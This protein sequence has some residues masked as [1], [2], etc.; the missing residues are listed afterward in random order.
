ME[1]MI[2]QKKIYE[3]R[4]RK[5]ILD[6]DLAGL[7]EVETRVMNQNVKRNSDRFPEDFMFQLTAVEWEHISSSQT[8]MME[9]LPKNRTG[10]YLPYAF[11]EHGVTML[12]SVLKSKKAVQ[13]NLAIVRAFISLRQYFL[14]YKELADQI[15]ELRQKTGEHDAQLSQIYIAIENLLDDKSMQKTWEDRQR[16]GF[17]S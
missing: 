9:K 11:T 15:H 10:T 14:N 16:I 7:Y 12:A 4:G 13:M 6:F 3:L 1:L 17:K 5:V 2:I 8:V